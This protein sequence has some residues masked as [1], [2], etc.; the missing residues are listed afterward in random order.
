M[1]LSISH[2]FSSFSSKEMVYSLFAAIIPHQPSKFEQNSCNACCR[3]ASRF[4]IQEIQMI[5]QKHPKDAMML[6]DDLF[7]R[8]ANS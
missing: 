5:C 2:S 1:C 4:Q 6:E 7:I 8:V 3:S